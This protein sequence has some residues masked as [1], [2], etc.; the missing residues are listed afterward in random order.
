VIDAVLYDGGNLIEDCKLTSFLSRKKIE[1]KRILKKKLS[2]FSGKNFRF[3]KSDHSWTV[4]GLDSPLWK[5]FPHMQELRRRVLFM[6]MHL[7]TMLFATACFW[8][9]TLTSCAFQAA[10]AS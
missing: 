2:A 9:L 6:L 4:V 3:N 5:E 8:T 1:K 10:L 7:P